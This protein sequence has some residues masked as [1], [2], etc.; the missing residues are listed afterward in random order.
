MA[1]LRL[2]G[3]GDLP[4]VASRVVIGTCDIS[5][6]GVRALL[7][8]RASDGT[9]AATHELELT[10]V[11]SNPGGGG[12]AVFTPGGDPDVVDATPKMTLVN[13]PGVSL[14][15]V[16]ASLG[17][18]EEAAFA[19]A[20]HEMVTRGGCDSVVIVAALRLN[21]KGND[22]FFQTT[23]NGCPPLDGTFGALDGRTIVN[24]GVVAALMHAMRAGATPAACLLTRGYRVSELGG[25]AEAEAAAAADAMGAAL[26]A[27][28]GSQTAY[29]SAGLAAARLW[30][31]NAAAPNNTD[32]MY[33]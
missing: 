20:V 9:R 33:M 31:E 23:M 10:G 28:L 26:A 12:G 22:A 6:V 24:D 18:H 17:V 25:E 4:A 8:L 32:R 29:R 15:A 11:G 16:N 14:V 3:G 13:I 21:A 27:A 30:Q 19:A 7:G 2:K 5:G 1:T